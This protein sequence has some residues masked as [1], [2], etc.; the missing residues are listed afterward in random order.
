MVPKM[1]DIPFEVD[2]V[3]LEYKARESRDLPS[4]RINYRIKV[5]T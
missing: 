5:I 1:S 4:I 2:E 3:S